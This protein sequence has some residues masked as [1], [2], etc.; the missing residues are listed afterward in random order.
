MKMLSTVKSQY[1]P[2]LPK[3]ILKILPIFNPSRPD[4]G[5]KEKIN[6]KFLF[7]HLFVVLLK[8]FMKAFKATKKCENK[9]LS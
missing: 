8:G 1:H 7:S 3:P 9:N 2:I 4:P 6:L 5:E